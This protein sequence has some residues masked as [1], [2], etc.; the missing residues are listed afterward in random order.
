MLGIGFAVLL[1]ASGGLFWWKVASPF[2]RLLKFSE[3]CE[4]HPALAAE[5]EESCKG[6]ESVQV[7]KDLLIE[8]PPDSRMTDAIV[9]LSS[10]VNTRACDHAVVAR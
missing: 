4:G 3:D 2:N 9:K 1:G 8:S 6:L 5:F 7:R 10:A